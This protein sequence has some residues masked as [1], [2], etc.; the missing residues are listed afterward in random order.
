[1]PLLVAASFVMLVVSGFLF[2]IGFQLAKK[3]IK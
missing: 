2:G 3:L 1:M